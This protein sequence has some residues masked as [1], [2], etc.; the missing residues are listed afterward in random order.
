METLQTIGILML[1]YLILPTVDVILGVMITNSLFFMPSLLSILSLEI[2]TGKVIEN[3]FSLLSFVIQ[4]SALLLWPIVIKI[5]NYTEKSLNEEVTYFWAI[6]ITLLL[7]SFGWWENFVNTR[8]K[9]SLVKWLA[10]F[11]KDLE[12]CRYSIYLFVSIW[13]I[14]LMFVGMVFIQYLIVENDE[15]YDMLKKLFT[16]FVPAFSDHEITLIRDISSLETMSED[17]HTMDA[18]PSTSIWVTVIQVVSTIFCYFT[19][20]FVCKICIQSF[21]FALP[22]SLVI[23]STVSFLIAMT[24]FRAEPIDKC[25][26]TNEFSPFEY[27]FWNSDF[28]IFSLEKWYYYCFIAIWIITSLSQTWISI[29]IWSSK[30]KR[31]AST[32]QL[33]VT[34]FYSSV[35]I[36]QSLAFNRRRECTEIENEEKDAE[37]DNNNEYF[38]NQKFDNDMYYNSNANM[39]Y[40]TT[41]K[42]YSTTR[43]YAC[44]TMWHETNDEMIQML[45]SIMRMDED[46]CAR[47]QAQQWF[48]VDSVSTEYYEFESM[49]DFKFLELLEYKNLR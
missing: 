1:V 32:E 7:I 21:S 35:I 24:D 17:N 45:K 29:N 39:G 11:K 36:D 34:P 23:P 27:M 25:R 46:Q 14:A 31:L 38:P 48:N 5:T 15:R 16:K 3:L 43:I 2:K 49:F 26:L 18:Y 8:S 19:S 28:H 20:K 12:N 47:R 41:Q 9:N 40:N 22:I 44:A 42:S 10:S 13:K 37:K 6:P 4:C 30:S 33:F